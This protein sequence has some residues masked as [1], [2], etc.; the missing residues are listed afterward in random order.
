VSKSVTVRVPPW[1][2]EEEARSIIESILARI[3]GRLDVD[4]VRRMLGISPEELREDLEI[5][6]VEELRVKEKGRIA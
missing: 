6:S 4:E 3:G 1:L 2:S 5:Y